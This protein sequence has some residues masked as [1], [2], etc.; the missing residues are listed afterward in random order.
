[1]N[2]S[3]VKFSLIIIALLALF[4]CQNESGEENIIPQNII[5]GLNNELRNTDLDSTLEA[6]SE[7]SLISPQIL[8]DR[9]YSVFEIQN[10]N[11][12]TDEQNEQIIV[13]SPINNSKSTFKIYIADFNPQ[14]N[15]YYEMYT[16]RISEH[17]LNV[18]SIQTEDITGDHFQEVI[19]R[20]IDNKELQIFEIYKIIIVKET[21]ELNFVK[22]FSQAADG[23][24]EIIKV[25][26]GNDYKIDNLNG[27]SYT[28]ELQKKNP[29]DS[30]S[31][32]VENYKWNENS[33]IYELSTIEKARI[34]SVSNDNLIKFYRGTSDDYLD[35]LSGPWFKTNDL[36]G[37]AT[38]NMN[39]I[40]QM[41][42]DEQT[43]TFYSGGIQESF[44]WAD[45][46]QPIKYRNVLSFYDVRNNFLRTMYFSIYIYI[47]SF[48]SIRIKIIGNKRW[49][50]TYTQLTQNLQQ[51]LT[52]RTNENSLISDLDIKGLYKTNL[53]SEIIFDHP[54]YH[55]KEE[56]VESKGIY[57]IYNLQDDLILE[58]KE[59]NDNG[60][61]EQ[62]KTYKMNYSETID[63]LKIIRTI[64]LKKG[65]LHSKGI[66][67][68]S[69]SE[70]HFEQIEKINQETD[71][72]S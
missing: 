50:G 42:P 25:D 12:D 56:S 46:K 18:A 35:F 3:F 26:R 13:A 72:Q 58:M 16:D 60:L 55:L 20:G 66:V 22:I 24:F 5:P 19:I 47:D 38:H 7:S 69:N 29:E 30:K 1:M 64:S 61:S 11:I 43:L 57:T 32:I 54:E 63:D 31:M 71:N 70:L 4:S 10:V 68:E 28:V 36:D 40:F 14:T 41:L 23:D 65:N 59:L 6:G 49:G 67:L 51:I 53:N 52:D 33:A 62:I 37:V 2:N 9:D 21:G 8:I 34:T 15:E 39:E 45:D 48:D 17:N 27:L 44:T